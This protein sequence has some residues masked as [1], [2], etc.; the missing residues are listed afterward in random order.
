MFVTYDADEYLLL[1]DKIMVLS[2]SPE[3]S[4][5]CTKLMGILNQ[6]PAA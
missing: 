1:V 4:E 5:L 2:R 6:G 3:Y